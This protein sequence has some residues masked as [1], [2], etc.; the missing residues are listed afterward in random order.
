METNIDQWVVKSV[1]PKLTKIFK[2]HP[3]HAKVEYLLY[4]ALKRVLPAQ[5][6]HTFALQNGK[7]SLDITASCIEMKKALGLFEPE[8]YRALDTVL[9]PGMT[10][11]DAGAFIGDFTLYSA[12]KVGPQGKVIAFEASEREYRRLIKNIELNQYTN[13]IP[14]LYALWNKPTKL[15]FTLPPA[16]SGGTFKPNTTI[17]KGQWK[18]Y[19]VEAGTLDHVLTERGVK[20]VN[21]IKVDIEG[22]E[23]EFL[24][25]A[26][27]TLDSNPDILLVLS[28]HPQ[29]GVD[30]SKVERFLREKGFDFYHTVTFAPLSKLDPAITDVVAKRG[31][32]RQDRPSP[33]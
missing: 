7:M 11:V 27:A 5:R 30:V 14:L 15:S 26:S 9:S 19:E 33:I 20:T 18:T 6:E 12:L 10:M 16:G 25:G 17:H 8:S 28:L 21:L 31:H 4:E 2:K 32:F 24:E 13:V 22:A 23:L 1:F 3:P 29:H